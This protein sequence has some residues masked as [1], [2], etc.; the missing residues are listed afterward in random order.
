MSQPGSPPPPGEAPALSPLKRAFLALEAAE[1]RVA[2]LERAAR[3][4]IAIVGASCRVPGADDPT[5]FWRVLESG[6]EQVGPTP[7]DRWDGDALF[8]PNPETPGRIA[9]R[10][11]GYLKIPIDRFDAGLFG[12]APREAQGMDP[13]Q[14]LLLEVAWEALENAGKAP[15][16]LERTPTGVYVGLAAGDYANMELKSHDQGLLDSHFASGIAH[17]IASG[18]ISYLLG[19][20]GPS[21]TIDTACSSSLVS[22]HLACQALRS[23][24]CTMALAGGVNLML[25]PDFRSRSRARG[26]S[27]PTGAA[28]RSTRAPTAS[29]A[30]K[31][32]ASWCSSCC[33][34]PRPMATACSRSSA[35][36]P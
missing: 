18:R 16:R 10:R 3:A 36:A 34:T 14:R 4:P 25:A 11:A 32:A 24:D 31:G 20:Q 27:R 19:L 7:A 23:G 9:A 5:A 22:I 2:E 30:A 33:A 21:V 13:Q 1:A 6:E 28:R 17:S 35:G 29:R 15:N 26:C 12:I 8:D